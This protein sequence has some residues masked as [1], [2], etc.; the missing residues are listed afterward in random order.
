MTNYELKNKLEAIANQTENT[1]EKQLAVKALNN[2]NTQ[3]TL[4]DK[5]FQ[6]NICLMTIYF[7]DNFDVE[8]LFETNKDQIDSLRKEFNALAIQ[9]PTIEDTIK[10]TF[11]WFV[12]EKATY[13]LVNKLELE[14]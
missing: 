3:S 8:M 10:N 14:L 6:D 11:V 5:L 13:N 4:I 7:I 12:F 1:I 2:Y 9:N